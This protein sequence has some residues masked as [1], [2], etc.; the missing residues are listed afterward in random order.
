MTAAARSAWASA[1]TAKQGHVNAKEESWHMQHH[2]RR[3]EFLY[4]I[5]ALV[6][7]DTLGQ[8]RGS[9]PSSRVEP[10]SHNVG[11]TTC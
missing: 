5:N 11:G 3:A 1:I 4:C 9:H 6:G 2:Q 7:A 8:V 10:N